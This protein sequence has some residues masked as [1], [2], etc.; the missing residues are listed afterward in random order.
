MSSSLK[1]RPHL[2]RIRRNHGLLH[3]GGRYAVSGHPE[4]ARMAQSSPGSS[5]HQG[6]EA[7]GLL[8]KAWGQDDF[9]GRSLATSRALRAT[10]FQGRSH[11]RL[12]KVTPSQRVTGWP[13]RPPGW[14]IRV[15][16]LLLEKHEYKTHITVS[17]THKLTA[18]HGRP[19]G[20]RRWARG[21]LW[22]GGSRGRLSSV[23]HCQA[24]G[25]GLPGA[26]SLRIAMSL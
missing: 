14:C 19:S 21:Q 11:I 8:P 1:R 2:R 22:H 25:K 10:H 18:F 17:S 23:S 6:A 26:H 24:P 9:L 3:S 15:P 7:A 4:A 13:P 12:E 16:H 20:K 5:T